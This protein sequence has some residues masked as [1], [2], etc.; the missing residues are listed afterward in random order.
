MYIYSRVTFEIELEMF[1]AGSHGDLERAVRRVCVFFFFFFYDL[2]LVGRT[3]L[4]YCL[5]G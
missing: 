2:N 1:P 4:R 5:F 3:S